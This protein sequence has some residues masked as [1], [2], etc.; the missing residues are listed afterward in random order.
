V[1][2]LQPSGVTGAYGPLTEAQV[3]ALQ[4]YAFP[5]LTYDVAAAQWFNAHI[6]D[7]GYSLRAPFTVPESR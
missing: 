2:R 1:I 4:S 5:G 7:W 6:G 3:D